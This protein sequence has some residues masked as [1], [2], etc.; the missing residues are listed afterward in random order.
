MD[1]WG[2]KKFAHAF[3]FVAWIQWMLKTKVQSFKM[4]ISTFIYYYLIDVIYVSVL[5][6]SLLITIIILKL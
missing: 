1:F 5:L 2:Y 3:F 6:L 4:R